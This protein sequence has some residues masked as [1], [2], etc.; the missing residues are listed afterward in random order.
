[1]SQSGISQDDI[2][3]IAEAIAG[4][5]L[6]AT[7]SGGGAVPAPAPSPAAGTSPGDGIFGTIDEAARAARGAFL[8]LSAL[9]LTQRAAIIESMRQAMRVEAESLARL[10]VE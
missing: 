10:A 7:P 9:G 3:R 2:R 5:L 8:A 4:K 6:V 1:M